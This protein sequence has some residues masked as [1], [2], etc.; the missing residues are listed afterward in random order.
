MLDFTPVRE[1]EMTI[2]DLAEGLGPQDLRALTIEMLDVMSAL[3]ADCV[4][5]DVVFVPD[6]PE[7]NDAYATSDD[8]VGL[9]WTLGHVIVHTT[10]TAEESAYLAVELAR[11]VPRRSG[12]ARAEVPWETV[13]TIAQVHHRLAESRRMRLASLDMWPDEPHL[14]NNYMRKRG[15]YIN[16]MAQFLFGLQHD[17]SHVQQIANIVDQAKAAR[18]TTPVPQ[19][20]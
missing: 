6:D 12:R 15:L 13:T 14:E 3:V 5:A 7:A 4:D 19:E 1:E 10:A 2:A 11:G 20:Y 16:A 8:E 17:D 18:P 9:S